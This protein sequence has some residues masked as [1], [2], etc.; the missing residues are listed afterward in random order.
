[1]TTKPQ[2]R[3]RMNNILNLP[4]VCD[5]GCNYV[6]GDM[7]YDYFISIGKEPTESDYAM[8]NAARAVY[9][10]IKE[11]RDKPLEVKGGARDD[12]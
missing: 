2:K 7:F 1:M 10:A 4:Y 11:E 5:C 12:D 9:Q 6:N 3:D 8:F